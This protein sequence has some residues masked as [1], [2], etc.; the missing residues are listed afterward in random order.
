MDRLYSRFPGG[1]PGFGLLL[2]RLIVAASYVA[3]G[4]PLFGAG[5]GVCV[6]AVVLVAVAVLLAAGAKTS[7]NAGLGG[8]CAVFLLA[9]NNR[10]HWFLVMLLACL[11]ISLVLLGPGGYSLDA[12]LSGWRTIDLSSPTQPDRNRS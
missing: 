9:G 2:L 1:V 8:I 11:S 3:C 10:D 5:L 12:R 6:L 7:L 4:I